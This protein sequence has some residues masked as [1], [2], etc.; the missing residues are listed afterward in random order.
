MPDDTGEY[1][2]GDIAVTVVLMESDPSAAP[3]GVTPD[4]STENWTP[5][6]IQ[7]TKTKVADG[8][9]WWKTTLAAISPTMAADLNFVVDYTY[10]DNPISTR[11]EPINRRSD[12]FQLWIYDFLGEVGYNQTRDFSR[13]IRAF[14]DAQR[15]ELG[16]H[17]GFTIFVV[18]STND[19][20]D[21][22]AL[23][24]SF[25]RAFAYAGGR[26]MVVPSGRPTSSF[27]H[28]T[29]HMFWARDEYT[30]EDWLTRRGY[31]NTQNLNAPHTGYTQLPSIMASSTLLDEAY[32]A[33]TSSPSTLAMIGWQDTDGDG[34]FDVLDVPLSLTGAGRYD[35]GAGVYRFRGKSAVGTLPNRNSSGLQNDIT[36]NV[37]GRAEYRVDGGA[38][39]T[40]ATYGSYSADLDLA[41]PMA[42]GSQSIEIRTIDPDTGVTSSVFHGSTAEPTSMG[43]PGINGF[44]FSDADADGEFDNSE[45]GWAGWT[46][47]LVDAGGTPLAMQSTLEPDNYAELVSIGTAL[48]GV[49]VQSIGWN[50]NGSVVSMAGDSST[51]LRGFGAYSQSNRR[52]TNV[53]SSDAILLRIDF[54]TPTSF[55]SLDAIGTTGV[56]YGRLE[57]FDANGNLIER[58]TTSPL[59]ISQVEQMSVTRD[60][61]D[62][63]YVLAKSHLGTEIAFDNLQVGPENSTV[64][65]A[66]GAFH[67]QSLPAGA[68]QVRVSPPATWTG[69]TLPS[70]QSVTIAEGE[71]ATGADFAV[72]GGLSPW[73]NPSNPLDVDGN[74]SVAPLDAL[75]VINEINVNGARSLAGSGLTAPPFLD[76]NNDGEV[77]PIDVL[78]V[79]NFL[80]EAEGEGGASSGGS[81][82]G[83]NNGGTA[84]SGSPNGEQIDA[85]N[86]QSRRLRDFLNASDPGEWLRA[87]PSRRANHSTTDSSPPPSES[88]D[89]EGGSEWDAMVL[90]VARQWLSNQPED[91]HHHDDEELELDDHDHDHFELDELEHDHDETMSKP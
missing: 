49:T 66:A 22:F 9:A 13:D 53:F 74:G 34:I 50:A 36:I 38:W 27:A 76:T 26:F 81:G 51:G 62:I 71:A 6:L 75:L 84:G 19:F 37:V 21:G 7:E 61:P 23:P 46:V 20:D 31:Y 40:A 45:A 30:G 32:A 18:N 5:A 25:A 16:A 77:T 91:E 70:N 29:G 1:M 52:Y 79:I 59:D 80:N 24:G 86:T 69:A 39:T 17:W 72:T 10:A 90:E 85:F 65:D 83:G 58:Y 15:R 82:N 11:Y 12:D 63:A 42:S 48:S 54:A 87:N 56:D 28:E 14:N 3:P 47:Q 33:F 2:L 8:L 67:L 44:V 60:T 55:V 57:A 73:H 64:T 78:L 35:A 41:I 89:G 88:R 43:L 4:I 68:Y